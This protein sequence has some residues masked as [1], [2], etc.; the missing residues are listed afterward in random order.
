MYY[1]FWLFD[2][3]SECVFR[4]EWRPAPG[5]QRATDANDD[6]AKLIFGIVLSL[7]NI[8]RQLTADERFNTYSTS[9][10]KL[11][12]YESPSNLK[13]VF[14]TDLSVPSAVTALEQIYSQLYVEYVVKNPL[15][16]IEHSGGA[17]INNQLFTMGLDAY[18][19]SLPKFT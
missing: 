17:G 16:P 15:S 14:L 6:T 5:T 12:Y 1:S 11:H 2:R 7:R 9:Q 3:H 8:T 4:R 18:V 13:M 10:Y 19:Q